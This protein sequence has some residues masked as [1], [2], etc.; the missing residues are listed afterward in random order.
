MKPRCD[1]LNFCGDDPHID[2]GLVRPCPTFEAEL[3]WVSFSKGVAMNKTW[4]IDPQVRDG[5]EY[6]FNDDHYNIIDSDDTYLCVGV[7]SLADARLIA[8][9]PELLRYLEIAIDTIKGE[10][11]EEQW[12][13][14]KVPEMEKLIKQVKS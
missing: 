7:P 10:Y 5:E 4:T 13:D 2:K 3:S 11:P 9:A 1:C 8:A 14:Y 6:Y 12:P